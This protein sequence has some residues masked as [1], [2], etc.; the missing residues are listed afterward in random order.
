MA[1]ELSEIE[2]IGGVGASKA[3]AL[4]EAG[5]E[6]ILSIGEVREN[7]IGSNCGMYA[8]RFGAKQAE[9]HLLQSDG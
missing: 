3:E 1:D 2:D 8:S 9:K 4:R 7:R 5:Y 6:T